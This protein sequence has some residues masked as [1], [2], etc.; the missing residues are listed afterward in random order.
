MHALRSLSL[1]SGFSSSFTKTGGLRLLGPGVRLGEGPETA[2]GALGPLGPGEPARTRRRR[3]RPAPS[4]HRARACHGQTGTATRRREA[5][6]SIARGPRPSWGGVGGAGREQTRGLRRVRRA[7]R[8]TNDEDGNGT[9]ARYEADP[10]RWRGSR[11]AAP[12]RAAKVPRPR[13]R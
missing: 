9:A 4:A 11:R 3:D 8:P 1:G 12:S 2:V 6:L 5:T 10:D 7:D 13:A